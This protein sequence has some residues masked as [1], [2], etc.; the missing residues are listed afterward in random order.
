MVLIRISGISLQN[1]NLLH[2]EKEW[3][4]DN[5]HLEHQFNIIKIFVKSL[6]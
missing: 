2:S 6:S 4:P 5:N 3:K 1:L